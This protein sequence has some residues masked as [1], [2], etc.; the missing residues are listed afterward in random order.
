[1]RTHI[2]VLMISFAVFFGLVASGSQGFADDYAN[3]TFDA[4]D[5]L[6]SIFTPDPANDTSADLC[7]S[8]T[9]T[10]DGD[11]N[12]QVCKNLTEC[13]NSCVDNKCVTGPKPDDTMID[14][15]NDDMFD[16]LI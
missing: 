3:D 2:I 12:A 8:V 13:D 10:A 15:A 1:M 6:A 7:G 5:P 14:P 11:G 9:C 4:Y 16:M